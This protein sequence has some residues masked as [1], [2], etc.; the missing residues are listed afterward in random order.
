MSLKKEEKTLERR[1]NKIHHKIINAIRKTIKNSNKKILIGLI[2]GSAF[3]ASMEGQ[4]NLANKSNLIK[5]QISVE[6]TITG[7]E[8]QQ[9]EKITNE[10]LEPIFDALDAH[11]HFEA[12]KLINYQIKLNTSSGNRLLIKKFI[13]LKHEILSD[14]A[15]KVAQKGISQGIFRHNGELICINIVNSKSF[16]DLVFD[17]RY[18]TN[19][20]MLN[21]LS[22]NKLLLNS[23]S[24]RKSISLISEFVAFTKVKNGFLTISVIKDID[25]SKL[26]P[27]INVKNIPVHNLF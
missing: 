7:D 27:G 14:F 4:N 23:D 11:N 26:R 2:A 1:D 15:V 5:N 18:L 9:I 24:F 20:T 13:D 21:Y 10:V 8:K 19:Q 17:S 25:N 22:S 16:D 6:T 3:L 12:L